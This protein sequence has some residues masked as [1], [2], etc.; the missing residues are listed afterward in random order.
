MRTMWFGTRGYERW[1]KMPR[2][3]MERGQYGWNNRANQVGGGVSVHRSIAGHMEYG[4]EWSA[5]TVKMA[6]AIRDVVDGMYDTDANR[7]LIYFLMPDA[8]RTNVFPKLWA[9]PFLCGLG[10]PSLTKGVKPNLTSTPANSFDLPARSATFTVSASTSHLTFYTPIPPG[11]TAHWAFYGPSAQADKIEVTPHSGG[12]IGTPVLHDILDIDDYGTGFTTTAGVDGIEFALTPTSGSVSLT[13]AILQILPTGE[14]P[15]P[16]T[17]FLSGRG[18]S[19]C[20][21]D[22]DIGGV[23][24]RAVIDRD[25]EGLSIRFVER[26]SWL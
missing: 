10:A 25:R 26:G 21:V 14:T 13:T 16:P 22:G 20:Q 11:H 24:N 5:L 18:H 7:G 15:L 23:L 8:M 12:G 17:E 3:D 2:V 4:M 6:A 1:I 19:G 9:A